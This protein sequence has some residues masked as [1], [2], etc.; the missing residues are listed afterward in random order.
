MLHRYFY[1]CPS[2]L[3]RFLAI[4]VLCLTPSK[5]DVL[6]SHESV[7]WVFEGCAS[8]LLGCMIFP[9]SNQSYLERGLVPFQGSILGLHRLLFGFH[10]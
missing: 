8:S 1:L 6:C 4:R 5:L 7:G 9:Y 10:L 2:F 3:R